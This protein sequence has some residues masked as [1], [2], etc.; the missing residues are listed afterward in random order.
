MQWMMRKLRRGFPPRCWGIF[1]VWAVLCGTR[2]VSAT[3]EAQ[4]VRFPTASLST[5]NQPP[6]GGT[7]PSQGIWATTSPGTT[8][9]PTAPATSGS[10]YS[11]P[12]TSG[13]VYG[14]QAQPVT[15]GTPAPVPGQ[16]GVY[17]AAPAPQ[18]NDAIPSPWSVPPPAAP[19]SATAP[20][21][22]NYPPGQVPSYAPAGPGVA[23]GPGAIYQ[24]ATPPPSNWDPYAA[25]GTGTQSVF[26]QGGI[27]PGV[28]GQDFYNTMIKFRESTG[29]RFTWIP[30]NGGSE[31]GVDDLEL[32]ST[33]A[34]PFLSTA[35]PPLRVTPGFTFHW[36][37]G[38]ISS[39]LPQSQDM[40]SVTYDAYLDAAWNP[41]LT[42][43]LGGELSFR[44]GVYSDFKRVTADSLRFQGT[45][46]LTLNMTP[47]WKLKGGVMYL[48]RVRIKMLPA[49]GAIW[50]DNA[51][52]PSMEISILFPN[53]RFAMRLPR[54]VG[55]DI[56]WYVRGDYGGDSWTIK[57]TSGI[58]AGATER[59]DYNDLRLA[60]GLD[61]YRMRGLRGYIEVGLAFS[62]ELVYE[63]GWTDKFKPNSAVFLGGGLAF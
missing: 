43:V 36:W 39:A 44:I 20:P 58:N 5:Q 32:Y 55:A 48:D 7:N 42:P 56:W 53:P 51:S 40:P 63:A 35:G 26:P 30:G 50:V 1:L 25:P 24:G 12:T 15:P 61:F 45:G 17:G 33:F 13:G 8:I 60:T 37:N 6:T 41:Q 62:R 18:G 38:P 23:P 16:S 52:D 54:S 21:A 34:F 31:L 29:F 46:Y 14:S 3:A 19:P 11:A 28:G 47:N 57:R 4:R 10:V 2:V 49:G 27:F 59:V 9:Q 22:L